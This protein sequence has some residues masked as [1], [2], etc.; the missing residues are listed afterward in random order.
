M[1]R[2]FTNFEMF[3]IFTYIFTVNLPAL[4][5]GFTTYHA[6]TFLC[7]LTCMNMN[8]GLVRLFTS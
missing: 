6:L 8:T 4:L 3:T 5:V 2:K 7:M 1:M